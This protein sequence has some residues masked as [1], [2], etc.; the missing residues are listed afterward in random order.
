MA[1]PLLSDETRTEQGVV[2]LEQCAAARRY[3]TQRGQQRGQEDVPPL[4]DCAL[5]H[6]AQAPV[7]HLERRDLGVGEQGE[8]AVFRRRERTVL[9][10]REPAVRGFP[11]R[12]HTARC[13]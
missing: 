2:G 13:A 3:T 1:L 6:T 11:S 12:R 10:Y 7:H 8:Q 9:V 5:V 4:L